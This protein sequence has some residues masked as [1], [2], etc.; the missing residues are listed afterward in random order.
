MFNVT[1]LA[2]NGTEVQR[3]SCLISKSIFFP[4]SQVK[5]H[6]GLQK[7][8]RGLGRLVRGRRR[9]A[10]VQVSI[11]KATLYRKLFTW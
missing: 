10:L 7:K 3:L 1:Q 8:I 6:R 4:L 11:W 5:W 2:S 9:E